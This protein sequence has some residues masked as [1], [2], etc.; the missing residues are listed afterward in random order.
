MD[1]VTTIDLSVVNETLEGKW[2]VFRASDHVAMGHGESPMD[3]IRD[4][5]VSADDDNILL[6]RIPGRFPIVA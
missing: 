6:V 4:A 2:V 3:A 5:R 1:Q